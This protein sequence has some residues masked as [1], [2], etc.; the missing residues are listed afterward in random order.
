MAFQFCPAGLKLRAFGGMSVHT[1]YHSRNRNT[2]FVIKS[3]DKGHLWVDTPD[4]ELFIADQSMTATCQYPVGF[5]ECTNLSH[6]HAN[7]G[8]D[9]GLEYIMINYTDHLTRNPGMAVRKTSALGTGTGIIVDSGGF[10]ISRGDM[11]FIDPEQEI[12]W[13]NRN[14]DLGMLLDIP[15]HDD[16]LAIR[17]AKIQREVIKLWLKKK[18]PDL[19]LINIL[20]GSGD[21]LK[22]YLEVV[23]HP[24]IRRLAFGGMF[25]VSMMQTIEK[26]VETVLD[27]PDYLHHHVLG[28]THR[29]VMILLMYMAKVGLSPLIT[30]DSS[31]AL[32]LSCYRTLYLYHR[33]EESIFMQDMGEKGNYLAG[34]ARLSCNCLSGD[35]K[36][37]TRH[38]VRTLRECAGTN[39][40]LLTAGGAWVTAPIKSFGL[41]PLMKVVLTRNQR[42]KV[43]YAT[44]GHRWLAA[45]ARGVERE[46]STEDLRPG[47]YLNYTL[48]KSTI[49]RQKPSI[50]GIRHGFVFG[51]GTTDYSSA[52]YA[53]Y[54]RAYFCGKKDTHI[55]HTYFKLP[56][57]PVYL[58]KGRVAVGKLPIHWKLSVPDIDGS[59]FGY[60]CGFIAGLIAA[61]GYV[62]KDGASVTLYNCDRSVLEKVK[63]IATYLGIATYQITGGKRTRIPKFIGTSKLSTTRD[64]FMYSMT[65]MATTMSEAMF[66]NLEHKR[67]F[68]RRLTGKAKTAK[69][70]R[71]GWKVVDVR[72]TTRVEEV[73]CAVVP[74]TQSFVLEDFLLTGNCPVCSTLVYA[75][76]FRNLKGDIPDALVCMHNVYTF[77]DWAQHMNKLVM[78]EPKDV[79]KKSLEQQFTVGYG[80]QVVKT[81]KAGLDYIDYAQE[82]GA[83]KARQKFNAHFPHQS[84]LFT[85]SLGVDD[86]GGEEDYVEEIS[87]TESV[88]QTYEELFG[89]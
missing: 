52:P 25:F 10:Q 34:Q 32:Q 4:R 35:T 21:T 31:S 24:K 60:L 38:G 53:E 72:K 36:F 69:S 27:T 71:M 3:Q 28:V 46:I 58:A 16:S 11:D 57:K 68:K 73:F 17:A 49:S 80:A 70:T 65:F 43:V 88:L 30:C 33:I 62:G 48:P 5:D 9:L 6:F 51:D 41:Q 55:R 78:S 44:P 45:T 84:R 82:H 89:L 63:D 37:L 18:R 81:L 39:V 85:R 29:G 20:H 86:I 76:T 7:A 26:I 19:E 59:S 22:R 15:T 83:A 2:G 42:E 74:K 87:H 40:E 23:D 77:N 79:I 56:N 54:S 1:K 66:L 64:Y 8:K 61:D 50:T 67:R 14:A 13:Y 75:D 12:D 47:T